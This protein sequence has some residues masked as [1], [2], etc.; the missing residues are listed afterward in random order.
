MKLVSARISNFKCIEDSGE[1]A[2]DRVTCLVGKNESGKSTIL[3]ALHKL[4]PAVE[5]DADFND[6]VEYPR[7]HWSRYK[8]QKQS[9]REDNVLSTIWNLDQDDLDAITMMVG[10][11][12]FKSTAVTIE[13]GYDNQQYWEFDVEE[14]AVLTYVLSSTSLYTEELEQLREVKTLQELIQQLKEISSPSERHTELLARVEKNFPNG[15][16]DVGVIRVLER[17]VPKFVY[18]ADYHR[19]PGQVSLTDLLQKANGNSYTFEDRVFLALLDLAGT[20]LQE[21]KNVGRFEEFVAELEAVSNRLTDTIFNYWSQNTHLEV[22]FRLDTGRPQD[23]PP[24][25]TGYV[26]RTRIRNSRHRV[27]VGF[28]ERSTGFVWFFSFLVW[29]SQLRKNY[30]DNLF[31]LLDEPGLNLHARAQQDLLRYINE[32]L[33]PVHQV[34]YT[35]HSPFLIDPE[36]LLAVRT[37]EDVFI[38]GKV[39]GTKVGDQVFSTD[40]DTL[41]PLQAALGYELTQTLFVGKNVL[42][43]EGPSDLLYLKWFSWELE[44]RGRRGLDK[45]WVVTPCG[46]IDKVGSFVTLFGGNQLNVAVLTDFHEGDKKKIRTLKESNLLKQGHIFSAE[47]FV[48]QNEADIEDLL[49]RTLYVSLVNR[50]YRLEQT[51]CL[52]AERGINVPVRVVKEVEQHFAILPPEAPAFDHYAPSAFLIEAGSGLRASL[53]GMEEAVETF[54]NLFREVNSLLPK[55]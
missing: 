39:D 27:T 51:Q 12:A 50:C 43:V 4:N 48:D 28:D 37:V 33:K 3:Q 14:N 8:E 25:H 19:L 11:E 44:Q 55:Q 30:G 7:R 47:M 13:K 29:F 22:D 23:P 34:M 41:F 38:N 49:G 35:T 15:S 24:F 20:D 40:A 36:N 6:V 26:F 1:F 10:P 46:G 42:L 18:F 5:A 16:V 17:R 21:F 9:S 52:P 54:E 53:P 32:C 31:I 2:V 45:R